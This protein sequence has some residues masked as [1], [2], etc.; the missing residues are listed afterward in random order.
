[1]AEL[2]TKNPNYGNW[3]S[4]RLLYIPVAITVLFLVLALWLP[5]LGLFAVISLLCFAYFA[6][7][8]HR[9]SPKGGNIQAKIQGLLLDHLEW[10][11]K[12]Q[13]IDTGCGNGSL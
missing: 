13:V 9:F 5:V 3:V 8:R 2:P 6:Y 10:D 7:A 11:G 12:G 1:M 4:A